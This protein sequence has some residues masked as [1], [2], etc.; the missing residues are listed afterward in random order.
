MKHPRIQSTADCSPI[1]CWSLCGLFSF[2]FI[3]YQLVDVVPYPQ[4][5]RDW[6]IGSLVLAGAALGFLWLALASHRKA[7]RQ[8]KRLK[9]GHCVPCGY[10][11][12]GNVSGV[13]PECG[14]AAIASPRR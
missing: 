3:I 9:N 6:V 14:T 10:D 2:L 4:M 1:I 7:S 5:K 11:L 13:C 12:T 8:R